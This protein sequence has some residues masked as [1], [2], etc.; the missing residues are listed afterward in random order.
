MNRIR[1]ARINQ[2]EAEERFHDEI[3][4]HFPKGLTCDLNLHFA[5]PPALPM[6][7]PSVCRADTVDEHEPHELLTASLA[8]P[9]PSRL[10]TLSTWR[11]IF[12]GLL[13]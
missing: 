11:C 5:R 13:C 4:R 3:M 6:R 1:I 8:K 12:S 2:S 10:S 9:Q 7:M